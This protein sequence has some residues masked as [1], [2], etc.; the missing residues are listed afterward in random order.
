MLLDKQVTYISAMSLLIKNVLISSAVEANAN[1]HTVDR[2][3][4]TRFNQNYNPDISV[5]TKHAPKTI[6]VALWTEKKIYHSLLC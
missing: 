2:L 1:S 3:S 6:E 4:Q 5:Y